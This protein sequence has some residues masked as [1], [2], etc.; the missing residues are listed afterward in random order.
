MYILVNHW[1]SRR[2][3]FESCQP[4]DTAHARNTVAESCG[5]IVDAILKIPKEELIHMPEE[6]LVY[7]NSTCFEKLENEW[8]K[9]VLVM[10]DFNDEP[11]DE[12]VLRYLGGV[13]DIRF[14]R[15]WK[16]FLSF[17]SE[18]K[19]ISKVFHLKNIT[20]KKVLPYSIVCGS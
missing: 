11:Y 5:K 18:K 2:G 1:P 16:E 17:V 8:N 14:C 19:G 6:L 12:S 7:E 4:N 20:S 9:N 13:P 15:G 10:G 3:K